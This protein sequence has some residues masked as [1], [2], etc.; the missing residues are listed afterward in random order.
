[1][2]DTKKKSPPQLSE[3]FNKPPSDD[4]D[5]GTLGFTVQFSN[6]N[7]EN[8]IVEYK[9]GEYQKAMARISELAESF[10]E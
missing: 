7:I 1:M 2:R 6:G 9:A 5:I 8:R 10:K 3:V 4:N